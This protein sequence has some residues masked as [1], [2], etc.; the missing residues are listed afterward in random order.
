MQN[1]A[2]KTAKLT[3]N[4][5]VVNLVKGKSS[6]LKV[7][8]TPFNAT[9]KI[10]FKSSNKKIATVNKKGKI[11]AKKKGTAYITVKAGKISKKVKVVVKNK[12]Y[13]NSDFIS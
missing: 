8:K 12:S 13:N 4:K 6:T 1:K 5:T 9:D 3:V 11:V 10:S 7:R 2:V